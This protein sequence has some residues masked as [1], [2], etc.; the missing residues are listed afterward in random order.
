MMI[1]LNENDIHVL[2]SSLMVM[3]AETMK[4]TGELIKK[5]NDA[6]SGIKVDGTPKKR[7]GRPLGRKNNKKPALKKVVPVAAKEAA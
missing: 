1:N 2:V 5:L 3:Q 7:P 4:V 6:E